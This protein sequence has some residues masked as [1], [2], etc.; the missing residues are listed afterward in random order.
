M[1]FINNKNIL[2]F[3]TGILAIL[4]ISLSSISSIVYEDYT[5]VKKSI[6]NIN[7]V[8]EVNSLLISIEEER[9]LSAIYLGS[10]AK[11][12]QSKLKDIRLEVDKRLSNLI[13]YN[14][15]T[16]D[17]IKNLQ[18]TRTK[19]DT[20]SE[21]YNNIFYTFYST[22]I[23]H[24]LLRSLD[25]LYDKNIDYKQRI[26]ILKYIEFS[27]FRE[28]ISL[29]N[30]GIS[31]TLTSLKKMS[32]KDLLLWN[33]LII[34]ESL[35]SL[36]ELGNILIANK[37]DKI[38]N[39]NNFYNILLENRAMIFHG[40]DTGEYEISLDDWSKQISKKFRY[41]ELAQHLLFT[42][43]M[44]R[45]N[46]DI[47]KSE[48]KLIQFL[49]GTL[50]SFLFFIII[51]YIYK[52]LDKDKQILDDR[53][54]DIENVLNIEQQNELKSLVN[55]KDIN[56]IYIFL[57]KVIKEANESKDLFLANM[58]HEI[59]TPLNGIV[60]FTQ[61]LK[62][63]DIS[64]EQEEFLT[65]I[66]NSSDNLLTIV[67][68]ILD[69][70]KIRADKIELEKIP[71]DPI[72]KFES[73]V[74]SY[75]ARAAEKN[76]EFDIFVDPTLPLSIMGDPTKIS[77]I[78]V[79]LISNA[80]KFT[81]ERG[82]V[83]VDI[84][85]LSIT[86]KYT[87]VK[88]AV[89]D[90]GIGISEEQKDKIFDAF[91]Q[92]DVSTSRK[93]GGTGLGLA[94]STKLVSFMGGKLD[95]ESVEGEGATF[96]FTISFEN[97]EGEDERLIPEL[98]D[99][100]V[101][102]VLPDR[103]MTFGLNK[104]LET[105]ISYTK[106]K[107]QIYYE[108][109]IF[110][111]DKSELPDL[112]FI[113]RINYKENKELE[114]YLNL[115]TRV[116]VMTTGNKKKGIEKYQN[117]IDKIFYKPVNFTKTLSSLE[118]LNEDINKKDIKIKDKSIPTNDFHH[119]N[120]L[121]AEDNIINQRLIEHLLKGVNVDVTLANNGKEALE[122]RKENNYKIIFMDIQM[123]VMGGIDAT[124][125]ILEF[126][127]ENSLDHIPIVALTANSLRGDK[128]KYIK[129][130]MDSYLSKPIARD[131]LMDIIEEYI[132]P[133]NKETEEIT[134]TVDVV[135][136]K[137]EVVLLED[138]D[139]GDK[140][141]L[142]F[143]TSKIIANMYK[144]MLEHIGEY[145]VDMVIDEDE[146]MDRLDSVKYDIVVYDIEPF[147]DMKC[148][149]VDLIRDTKARPFTLA[150]DDIRDKDFCCDDVLYLRDN[151]QTISKKLKA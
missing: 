72:E 97:I 32:D 134:E 30:S 34:Q 103:D 27:N 105:Y 77:Q 90:T 142:L 68:D 126:E 22:K 67:N 143:H 18:Y 101:G 65:I 3:L 129:A 40:S 96:F 46:Q 113:D 47:I 123:P 9:L 6:K 120:A 95:I 36:D 127:K 43:F 7:S 141:I 11:L 133:K 69:L 137:Q 14:I 2:I 38:L 107:Y 8:K 91:S 110:D 151:H 50:V 71:F 73:S 111:L 19:V 52:D 131:K 112:I 29:E 56:E 115:D 100:K 78:I 109:E 89:K 114:R 16:V 53:L 59:R 13:D 108:D 92:A 37:L 55:K 62:S 94:I 132:H 140:K 75:A 25:T 102:Y 122:Y 51:L 117:I 74:E 88:F 80:I 5:F 24:P 139:D 93:F 138:I 63:T 49:I 136:E 57:T 150:P 41:V 17:L 144:K 70:S 149:I 4:F 35:P 33:Q 84:T 44:D 79:N 15:K 42:S 135:E 85:K 81:P 87:M 45:V 76:I 39:K 148:M 61:L 10:E 23:L 99:K 64:D 124:K 82:K 54:K 104:N 60:G 21:D 116:V 118:I 106:A 83:S 130:G 119:I 146:F 26:Y 125:A 12:G 58:S 145:M 121:V 66:E 20:L 147:V 48:N 128:E 1:K 31:F 98:E 28:K 86:N